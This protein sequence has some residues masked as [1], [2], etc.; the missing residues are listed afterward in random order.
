MGR[1]IVGLGVGYSKLHEVILPAADR[2]RYAGLRTM[3]TD[4]A[5]GRRL[6]AAGYSDQFV[7]M[8]NDCSTWLFW[9]RPVGR[10]QYELL[11]KGT[12]FFVD[13]GSGPFGVTAHHVI[14]GLRRAKRSYG[15]VSVQLGNISLDPSEMLLGDDPARDVATFRIPERAIASLGK[16][17][18]VNPRKWPP[19]RPQEHKG[20]FFGGYRGPEGHI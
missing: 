4:E 16:R 14:D 18:H 3:P 2:R 13:A 6:I 12:V 15:D 20:V 10:S 8:A 19:S 11:N 9:Y 5:E 17:P 7:Q 1:H